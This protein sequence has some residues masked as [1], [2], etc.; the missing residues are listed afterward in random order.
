MDIIKGIYRHHHPFFRMIDP[1]QYIPKL[2]K[3]SIYPFTPFSKLLDLHPIHTISTSV[4]LELRL[5][6][7]ML[8]T[9]WNAV[10]RGTKTVT[11]EGWTRELFTDSE[12]RLINCSNFLKSNFKCKD[13]NKKHIILKQYN[14]SPNP[15]PIPQFTMLI[16]LIIIMHS[17]IDSPPHT[18]THIQPISLRWFQLDLFSNVVINKSEQLIDH[19]DYTVGHGDVSLYDGC[20]HPVT[21]HVH[22]KK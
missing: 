2:C 1:P 11:P 9:L 12:P 3:E 7:R 20:T 19:M 10:S 4:W 8:A 21:V 17:I 13:T 22:C 5:A 16:F 18:H 6:Q 14:A 15:Y